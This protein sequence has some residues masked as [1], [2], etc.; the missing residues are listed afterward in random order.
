MDI[1]AEAIEKAARALNEHDSD[2]LDKWEELLSF[3]KSRF[4]H[5]AKQ[6][7]YAAAPIVVADE[8]R[9]LV[10]EMKS[11]PSNQPIT[12]D[13]IEGRIAQLLKLA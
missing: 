11:R 9:D 13:D 8:L 1:S 12:V 3:E 2:S 7:L 10:R 5:S 6:A 4:T